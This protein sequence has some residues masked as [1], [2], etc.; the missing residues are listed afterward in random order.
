MPSRNDNRLLVQAVSSLKNIRNGRAGP[1][2]VRS[3][4]F[5]RRTY[6][7]R[8]S[9]SLTFLFSTD[10]TISVNIRENFSSL[11]DECCFKK[12]FHICCHPW[13]TSGNTETQNKHDRLSREEVALCVMSWYEPPGNT[14]KYIPRIGDPLYLALT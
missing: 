7:V 12:I 4:T 11:P 3:L 6:I 8:C 5:F 2:G 9:S 10:S 14:G 1:S 13:Q